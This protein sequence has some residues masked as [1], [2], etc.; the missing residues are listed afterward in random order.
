MKKFDFTMQSIL[1]VNLTLRDVAM[2]EVA[3]ASQRLESEKAELSRVMK[4]IQ[5]EMEQ[6]QIP[7]TNYASYL[8]QREK[9]LK[10]LRDLKYHQEC[11]IE[12]A[13]KMLEKAKRKLRLAF[14][15]VRKME[16]ASERQRQ[17]WEIELKREEQGINDE[18]GTTRSYQSGTK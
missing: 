18:I 5:N 4:L 17:K 1:N 9:F 8:M 2:S 7:S 16:K 14:V 10:R 11:N 13:E 3:D 6:T 15:E 12:A